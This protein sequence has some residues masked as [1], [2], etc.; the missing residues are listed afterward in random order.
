MRPLVQVLIGLK[1]LLFDVF[2]HFGTVGIRAVRVR[3]RSV[4]AA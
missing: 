1:V 2:A 4:R 3:P